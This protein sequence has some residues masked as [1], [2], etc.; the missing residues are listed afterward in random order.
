MNGRKSHMVI[1]FPRSHID[2]YLMV[3]Q[4]PKIGEMVTV[5]QFSS[6]SGGYH[7]H[8]AVLKDMTSIFLYHCWRPLSCNYIILVEPELISEIEIC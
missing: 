4:G 8:L 1:D 2:L 6:S 3:S 7:Q 5:R